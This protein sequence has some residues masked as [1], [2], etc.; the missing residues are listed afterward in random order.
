[1]GYV[2]PLCTVQ[3]QTVAC[4]F[5]SVSRG[6][7]MSSARGSRHASNSSPHVSRP[8]PLPPAA[9]CPRLGPTR[10]VP[11][12]GPK[13]RVAGRVCAP[14]R[15]GPTRPGSQGGARRRNRPDGPVRPRHTPSPRVTATRAS[16]LGR[17][18]Q[19]APR[20]SP[21]PLHSPSL[22]DPLVPAVLLLSALSLL[23]LSQ[24]TAKASGGHLASHWDY[25]SCRKLPAV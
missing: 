19:S 11:P 9:L 1:M 12:P 5:A 3:Q 25:P 24:V 7:I 8:P 22:L 17:T 6:W 10:L 14:S 20:P 23:Q 18:A 2:V 21:G 4:G 16:T 13:P 15:R